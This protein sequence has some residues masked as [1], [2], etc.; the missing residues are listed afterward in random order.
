MAEL[1][2][3]GLTFQEIGKLLGVS[4][5]YVHRSL[6]GPKA[7]LRLAIR[8]SACG[9][10][11]PCPGP[12]ARDV[13]CLDCARKRAGTTFAQRLKAFR[14]AVGFTRTR[15]ALRA[16]LSRRTIFNSEQG[17]TLPTA[18]TIGRLA[19]ALGTTSNALV[20]SVPARRTRSM[21]RS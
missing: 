14:L 12:L 6:S 5:Q 7:P 13:L 3:E 10:D 8:C 16:E 9:A 4:R 20:G 21:P 18:A 11:V 15:L 2:S 17:R 19:R 1:W